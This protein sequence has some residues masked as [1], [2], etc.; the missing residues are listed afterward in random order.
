MRTDLNL[1]SGYKY[2]LITLS[3]FI[4]Y[5][6]FQPPATVLCRK[7]GP[8]LFLPGIC[9]FWGV[10]IIGFGFAQNWETLVGLRLALGI[11]EAGYFPGE[12][13]R[14]YV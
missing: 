5:V 14:S 2:S 4:T 3:F 8:R 6:L 13:F 9:L 1:L 12:L 10:L 11:L 7:I